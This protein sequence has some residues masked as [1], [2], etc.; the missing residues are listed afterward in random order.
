MMIQKKS[1]EELR[2]EWQNLRAEIFELDKACLSILQYSI[3]LTSAL[4][5]FFKD[6]LWP[7]T[8][9]PGTPEINSVFADYFVIA[10]SIIWM[11]FYV[12]VYHKRLAIRR[13]GGYL[14]IFVESESN[15]LKWQTRLN[16]FREIR[17]SEP[18]YFLAKLKPEWVEFS[19]PEI[20]QCMTTIYFCLNNESKLHCYLFISLFFSVLI[21][22][23]FCFLAQF[24]P[25][26]IWK[27]IQEGKTEHNDKSELPWLAI[28]SILFLLL[29]LCFLCFWTST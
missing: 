1:P 12:Y 8:S 21:L 27:Q 13:I 19:L 18:R 24:K 23:L 28:L 17:R 4:S 9:S 29:V 20:L 15:Y 6:E 11:L 25:D 3:L 7:E 22:S 2:I 14:T 5:V 16:Q 10:L 26:I